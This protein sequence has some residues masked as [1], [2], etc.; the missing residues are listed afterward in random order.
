MT[1]QLTDRIIYVCCRKRDDPEKPSCGMRGS[2]ELIDLFKAQL[3]KAGLEKVDVAESRC[4]GACQ[5]G[6]T[7]LVYPENVWYG[8]VQPEDVSE[9]ITSHIKGNEPVKRLQLPSTLQ[10]IRPMTIQI[11][12][13]APEISLECTTGEVHTLS[14]YKGRKNVLINFYPLDFT[15][16]CTSQNC[17][18][19]I[20]LD[21]FAQYNTVVM[22]ISVDSRFCH[23]AFQEKYTIRHELL[24]D[25]HR[26][27]SKEY[28]VLYEPMNCSKRAYF[29]V[30]TQ[31]IVRWKK[32]M[33]ELKDALSIQELLSIVKTNVEA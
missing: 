6:P 10:K 21:M 31:G 26:K 15:P 13:P 23:L 30:D 27:A 22:P 17:G 32:V 28:G 1:T 20:D 9:I 7:V 24:S 29:F 18:F 12:H 5:T 14:M 11:G 33:E 2:S 16:V 8:H 3:Q 19:S 4:L 25:I